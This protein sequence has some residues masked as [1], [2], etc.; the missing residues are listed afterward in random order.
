MCRDRQD[1]SYRAEDTAWTSRR[2]C[3]ALWLAEITVTRWRPQREPDAF[4]TLRSCPDRSPCCVSSDLES[5][6]PGQRTAAA[7]DH[8]R[9]AASRAQHGLCAVA[10]AVGYSAAS[11]RVRAPLKAWNAAAGHAGS[12]VST[13]AKRSRRDAWLTKRRGSRRRL[14]LR[15]RSDAATAAR[16]ERCAR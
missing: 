12:T 9:T 8:A 2:S 15:A 16:R 13:P 6:T 1:V 7:H 4:G 14:D 10:G 3:A 11:P 5:A